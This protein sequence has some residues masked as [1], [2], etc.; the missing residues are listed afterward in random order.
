MKKDH[1]LRKAAT[2]T[3]LMLLS[4][5]ILAGKP[6]LARYESLHQKAVTL[7]RTAE[8]TVHFDGNYGTA[9]YTAGGYGSMADLQAER[10]VTV[11]LPGNSFARN[12]YGGSVY[13]F[14]GWNTAADGSG[15]AYMDR[16]EILDIAGPWETVTLY[17]QWR[18]AF[19]QSFGEADIRPEADTAA[20][21]P[22]ADAAGVQPESVSTEE[23]GYYYDAEPSGMEGAVPGGDL[24]DRPGTYDETG[25]GST[26]ED[27][28]ENDS[29]E[30]SGGIDTETG[31]GD[32]GTEASA[33]PGEMSADGSGEGPDGSSPGETPAG[34]SGEGPEGAA[35]GG[36]SAAENPGD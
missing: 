19:G 16:A 11:T 30:E 7:V 29:G 20:L 14:D 5:V 18:T 6:A 17:A 27:P 23:G 33:P 32:P 1:L 8:Y 13:V 2:G 25:C 26:D 24:K 12:A 34:S 21:R 35:L 4:A 10:G 31:S 15:T 9:P 3:V 36:G 28:M 22:E